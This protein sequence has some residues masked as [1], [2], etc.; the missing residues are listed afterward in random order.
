MISEI[1]RKILLCFDTNRV[2]LER[3]VD[4]H[5]LRATCGVMYLYLFIFQHAIGTNNGIT[6]IVRVTRRARRYKYVRFDKWEGWGWTN[7]R[8][9]I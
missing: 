5:S 9:G 1:A 4:A 2:W 7:L 3:V 8:S 6:I